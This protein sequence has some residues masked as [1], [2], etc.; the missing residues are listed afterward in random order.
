MCYIIRDSVN[1][2]SGHRVLL[3]LASVVTGGDK[4]TREREREIV[5]ER[6]R[7]QDGIYEMVQLS[8]HQGKI[9]SAAQ[10]KQTFKPVQDV[11]KST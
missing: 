9:T 8:Q 2:C 5:R 11:R 3:P 1:R 6:D 7:V 10:V 4:K